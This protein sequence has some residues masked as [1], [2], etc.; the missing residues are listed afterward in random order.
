V[1]YSLIWKRL[2]EEWQVNPPEEIIR[3]YSPSTETVLLEC[4]GC[5]LGF[6]HPALSGDNDFYGLLASSP[7]YYNAW[8]WEFGWVRDRLPPSAEVLDV[9][10]GRGDFL[11]A[12]L[13]Q[14]RRAAGLELDEGAAAEASSRGL[15]IES[16][17]LESFA[18]AHTGEFDAACL[19]HVVEHLADIRSFVG[20]VAACLRPGGSLYLSV[21]NRDRY[22]K[23]PFESLDCPPHHL[24]RWGPRQMEHLAGRVGLRLVR[25]EFEPVN[26]TDLR[27]HFADSL[28]RWCAGKL[29]GGAF[30]GRWSARFVRRVLFSAPLLSLYGRTRFFDRIG[31]KGF[32]LVAHCRTA[33]AE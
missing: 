27:A 17:H 23:E 16:G 2:S 33:G 11:A 12:I 8:K 13:P 18:R 15:E 4:V 25:L 5:G 14:V 7:R 28:E 24:S 21:P 22:L 32:S 29:P 1:P 20:Q 9:G 10:C 6:F 30:L 3:K 19:F 26:L 31:L